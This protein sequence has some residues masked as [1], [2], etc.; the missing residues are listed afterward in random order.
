M[1]DVVGL[2]GAARVDAAGIR[3]LEVRTFGPEPSVRSWIS[4]SVGTG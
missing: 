3:A 2:G 4:L 1:P